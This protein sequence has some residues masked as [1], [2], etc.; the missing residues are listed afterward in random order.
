M[1]SLDQWLPPSCLLPPSWT[2]GSAVCVGGKGLDENVFVWCLS[3]PSI[4][5]VC[6]GGGDRKKK[7]GKRKTYPGL[8]RVVMREGES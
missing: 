1:R 8:T 4:H 3:V 7:R 5:T 6:L 2:K